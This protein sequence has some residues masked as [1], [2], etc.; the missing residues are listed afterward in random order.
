MRV[1]FIC[2]LDWDLDCPD[3]TLF[4]AVSVK[5]I[6]E[7]INVKSVGQVKQVASPVWVGCVQSLEG[8][9]RTQRLS[10]ARFVFSA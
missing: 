7:E 5:V 2:Q 4:L 10:E 1:N 9:K 6:P 8:L 3:L